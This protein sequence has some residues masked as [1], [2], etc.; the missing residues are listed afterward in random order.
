MNGL[1]T[2]VAHLGDGQVTI[3]IG[4]LSCKMKIKARHSYDQ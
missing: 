1:Y 2:R 4:K 3:N